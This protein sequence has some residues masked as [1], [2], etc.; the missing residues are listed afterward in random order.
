MNWNEANI[1]HREQHFFKRQLI[2]ASYIKLSDQ[3]L[4]QPSV[5]LRPLW[6]PIIKNELKRSRP[7]PFLTKESKKKTN[8]KRIHPMTLRSRQREEQ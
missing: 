7:K 4:S 2:E 3:P 1:I 8:D 6:L 5:E